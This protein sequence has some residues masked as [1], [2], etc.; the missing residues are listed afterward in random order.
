MFRWFEYVTCGFIKSD[1]SPPPHSTGSSQDSFYT[2]VIMKSLLQTC[3][4]S[5]S[6]LFNGVLLV[7]YRVTCV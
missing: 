1:L 5:H 2:D 3:L 7:L 4:F 6:L